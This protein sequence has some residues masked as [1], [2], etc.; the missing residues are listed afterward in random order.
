MEEFVVIQAPES[1]TSRTDF[2]IR[3]SWQTGT[4][5]GRQ[6]CRHN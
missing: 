5:M 6:W 3:S 1:V 2:G 4:E